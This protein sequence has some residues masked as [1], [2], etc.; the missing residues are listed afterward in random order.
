MAARSAPGALSYRVRFG[1]GTGH[2]D[3]VPLFCRA[4]P[5]VPEHAGWEITHR[6]SRPGTYRVSVYGS[7]NCTRSP[8]VAVS[9]DV[10][11]A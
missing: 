10:V 1:D 5:G 8:R 11:I 6:Y 7:I 9:L 3:P 2:Q 4:S